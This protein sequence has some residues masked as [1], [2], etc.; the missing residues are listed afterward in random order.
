MSLRTTLKSKLLKRPLG[1]FTFIITTLFLSACSEDNRDIQSSHIDAEPSTSQITESQPVEENKFQPDYI[2]ADDLNTLFSKN[3]L[4]FIFDVRSEAS[5]EQS[6]ITNALS[7][8]YGK[9][10][11]TRLTSAGLTKD[12]FIVTYCGCPRHL[13]SLSAADLSERGYSNIK[14]LYEGYWHWKDSGYP[15]IERQGKVAITQLKFKGLVTQSNN[16]SNN[17]ADN[18]GNVPVSGIDLFLKHQESGQLEAVAT[19]P[20]GEFEVEFNVYDYQDT[21]LFEVIIADINS[22]PIKHTTGQKESV[23]YLNIHL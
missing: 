1:I 5:F 4:P 20:E 16:S 12:S 23:N 7:M 8:P 18:T 13:S 2:S 17:L 22:S 21:D 19:N 6:H 14:V 11:D 9:T 15:V 3:E 10:D